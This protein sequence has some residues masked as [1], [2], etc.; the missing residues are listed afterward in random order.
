MATNHPLG[1]REREGFLRNGRRKKR[2]GVTGRDA[3][4]SPLLRRSEKRETT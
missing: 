2:G 4:L 3:P 1:G